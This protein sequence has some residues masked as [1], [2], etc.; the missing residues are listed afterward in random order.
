MLPSAHGPVQPVLPR[1]GERGSAVVD[2]VLVGGLLTMF[3]LAIIQLT[4]VLHVRNTLIDA[5]AS[6]ARYGTLADRNAADAQERTRSLISMALNE[7][8]ADQVST[9]EVTVQGMRTLEVTV[10][11]P[12]PVIGLIGPRDLLEVK[13]HAAVQP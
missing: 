9:Q 12:M 1:P 6:G 8:F 4:L 5:A 2:F 7:G 13:G 11:S 3:F 10:R